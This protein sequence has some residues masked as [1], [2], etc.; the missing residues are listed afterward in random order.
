MVKN[1]SHNPFRN[2]ETKKALLVA[3]TTKTNID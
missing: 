3:D 2:A 1:S